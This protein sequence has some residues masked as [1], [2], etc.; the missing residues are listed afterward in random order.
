LRA[1][2]YGTRKDLTSKEIII[3]LYWTAADGKSVVV[4]HS[5]KDKHMMNTSEN[6]ENQIESTETEAPTQETHAIPV[7]EQMSCGIA[8]LDPS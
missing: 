1:R 5:A 4:A 6:N 3:T 7:T 2:K 8:V